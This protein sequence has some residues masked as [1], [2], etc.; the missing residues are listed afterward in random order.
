MGRGGPPEP[1]LDR[2]AADARRA[3]RALARG[4]ARGIR[5]SR[6]RRARRRAD[7]RL[8][9][10]RRRHGRRAIRRRTCS[11][12]RAL[13]ATLDPDV[14]VFDGSG[15]RSRRSTSTRAS[16]SRTIRLRALNPYRVL[17][18]DLVSDDARLRATAALG[19]PASARLRL[20]PS[21]RSRAASPSSRAG[22]RR[23][24]T[25]TR[26]V[27]RLAQP[28]RPRRAARASSRGRS[29]HV[30]RRAEGGCDRRRRGGTRSSTA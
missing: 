24:T 30:S 14:V 18:S 16:S 29:R 15:A 2:V 26:V 5:P 25:S 7:D 4:P 6:D 27:V 17:I 1:E 19:K 8:P 20:R 28:L 23:S 9:A 11:K 3:R 13:A 21:S 22:P 10:C 12:A